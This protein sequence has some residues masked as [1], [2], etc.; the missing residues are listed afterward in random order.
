MK[1]LN[2]QNFF[3]LGLLIGLSIL[4]IMQE[5]LEWFIG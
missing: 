3:Y 1:G 2:S 5:L 4:I